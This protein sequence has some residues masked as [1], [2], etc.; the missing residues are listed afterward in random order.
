MTK[1]LETRATAQ[2]TA[3]A[4]ERMR[5]RAEGP[6]LAEIQPETRCPKTTRTLAIINGTSAMKTRAKERQRRAQK[7][8]WLLERLKARRK[9]SMRVTMTLEAPMRETMAAR[10]RARVEWI[11]SWPFWK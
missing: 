8:Q 3:K 5:I 9:P 7:L 1:T 6:M 2:R 10:M 4:T 11:V